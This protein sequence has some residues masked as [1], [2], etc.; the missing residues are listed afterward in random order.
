MIA[1]AAAP[2]RPGGRRPALN[3]R[4]ARLA[5]CLLVA[6][7]LVPAAGCGGNQAYQA[8]VQAER[9][10][11]PQVA[12]DHYL[13]AARQNPNS[14]VGEA[15]R[16]TAAGA[17]AFW[18]AEAVLAADEGRYADA[19][20]MWMRVLDIRPDHPT[21]PDMIL[22]LERNQPDAIAAVRSDYH[23]LGSASLAAVRPSGRIGTEPPEEPVVLAANERPA[24]DRRAAPPPAVGPASPEPRR[25]TPP[26]RR[27]PPPRQISREQPPTPPKPPPAEPTRPEPAPPKPATPAKPPAK[28]PEQTPPPSTPTVDPLDPWQAWGGRE[29]TAVKTLSLRDRRFPKEALMVDGVTV[30]LR[31]TDDDL[32]ADLDLLMNNKR[33]LKI[34]EL[35]LG[36]SATFRGQSGLT[37]RITVLRIHHKTRTVQ[38]GIKPA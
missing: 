7:L 2:G 15:L 14:A 28:P 35:P 13:M 22:Q 27:E 20:Q 21:A 29:F 38:L 34:R 18:E 16:R 37:Y 30:K 1:A 36:R 8:G 23:R 24:R 6:W 11:Q 4:F 5:A 32:E 25:E 3:P 26:P 19:W 9:R 12:Y 17:A 31:D 10:D 33:F